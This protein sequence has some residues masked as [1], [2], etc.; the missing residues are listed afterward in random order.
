MTGESGNGSSMLRLGGVLTSVFSL[1]MGLLILIIP[2]A[3]TYV[4]SVQLLILGVLFLVGVLLF[5]LGQFLKWKKR[6]SA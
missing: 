1:A 4:G 3:N 5:F 6:K 2:T